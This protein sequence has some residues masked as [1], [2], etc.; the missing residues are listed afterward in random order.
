MQ[1]CVSTIYRKNFQELDSELQVAL[2]EMKKRDP[3]GCS[4]SGKEVIASKT[5][6]GDHTFFPRLDRRFRWGMIAFDVAFLTSRVF[7]FP[8][9]SDFVCREFAL[10]FMKRH[11]A[12]WHGT[13]TKPN[14][15]V[16]RG[17]C[18]WRAPDGLFGN[19][20]GI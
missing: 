20:L 5:R 7:C 18:L 16:A 17:A 4:G 2:S 19:R 1:K 3:V 14:G 15:M 6:Y 11:H 10:P 13:Q 12:R 9:S 8:I